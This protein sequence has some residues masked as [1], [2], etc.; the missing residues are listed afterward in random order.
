MLRPW[1]GILCLWAASGCGRDPPPGLPADRFTIAVIPKDTTHVFWKS[2]ER[3][4]KE[5]GERLGA[6]IDWKGPLKTGDRASQKQIVEQFITQ[7]VD[8]IC[9]AP[10]D[11]T[12]LCGPVA[13]AKERGIPVVVYDSNLDGA[14]G[15]DF[16]C[17]VA[18]DNLEGGR[19]GGEHL[20]KL[21]DGKG[22][23]VLLRF[24]LGSASTDLREQGFLEVM[25]RHPGIEVIEKERY[26]GDG[27]ESMQASEN[28]LDKL[29]ACDG[30][31]TPNESTTFGML[32]TLKKHGLAG[33]RKFVG[34]DSSPP[35]VDGLKEGGLDGLVV[36]NPYRMGF[37]S[38][39]LIVSSLDGIEVPAEWDTGVQLVTRDNLEQP[40]IQA[41]IGA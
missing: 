31:F 6:R 8:G 1:F 12:S 13:A 10:V 32:Q 37:V 35:L 34:F 17:Y 20:A 38:V 41:L 39:E 29:R 33:R 4:A 25:A 26:G 14:P 27:S 22:K 23:V 7:K 16:L 18:T 21:L 28:L 36:Q 5:A 11:R 40:E 2:V 9:L 19:I 15:V 24:Q 30:V 3:G